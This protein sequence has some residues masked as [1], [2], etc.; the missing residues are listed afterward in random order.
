V[1]DTLDR[2]DATLGRIERR[3]DRLERGLLWGGGLLG[4]AHRPA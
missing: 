3:L 4:L 2:I 1:T